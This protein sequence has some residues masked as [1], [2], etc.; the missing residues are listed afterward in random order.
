MWKTWQG[1]VEKKQKLPC[2]RV[3]KINRKIGDDMKINIIIVMMTVTQLAFAAIPNKSKNNQH[4]SLAPTAREQALY[5]Q[6]AGKNAPDSVTNKV[7]ASAEKALTLA[8]VSRTEK[9]YILAIKRYNFILKYYPK[10]QQAKLA[11]IDKVSLYKEM[12]LSEPAN[13]N[14]KKLMTQVNSQK[15]IQARSPSKPASSKR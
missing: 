15:G 3:R 13:Y 7:T 6:L 5:E 14:Q 12:N 4:H 9:N 2:N 1:L 11:L 10:T 8:R